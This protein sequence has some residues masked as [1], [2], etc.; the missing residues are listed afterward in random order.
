MFLCIISL[1]GIIILGVLWIFLLRRFI[2]S[3]I[4]V[5]LNFFVGWVIVVSGGFINVENVMLL[6]FVIDMLLGI[7]RLVCLKV[8]MVLIVVLL[9]L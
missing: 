7:C 9:F 4:V 2:S 1:N 8:C 6:K 5:L 3:V